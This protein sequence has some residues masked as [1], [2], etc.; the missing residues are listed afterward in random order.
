M[1]YT[2]LK[3]SLISSVADPLV[4][5]L[6]KKL[7]EETGKE[8]NEEL[9]AKIDNLVRERLTVDYDGTILRF[10][11]RARES[12]YR[13]ISRELKKDIKKEKKEHQEKEMF[14][15]F[16]RNFRFQHMML[17]S[18]CIIL[19]LTGMPLKFPDF[20][21]LAFLVTLFGGIEN[22]TIIHRIGAVMLIFVAVY[23]FGWVIISKTGRKDFFGLIPMPK[24]VFDFFKMLKYF[25]GKSKE[26]PRFG[27]FSYIEKFDYWAVYWG[28]VIMI[29]SGL[30]LWYQDIAMKFMPKFMM[31][32]STEV[33]S[34][35]A[36]LATLSIVIWHFYNVHFN[37]HKFPG[38][39]TWW[40]GKISREEMIEEHPLEY[41]EIMNSRSEGEKE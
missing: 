37:P 31:D 27:R 15:R 28:C 4:A 25:A 36:L 21:P 10:S 7:E 8:L 14:L 17:M 30:I 35:E 13:D 40:H 23:H 22:S 29:G 3:E 16:G 24:D 2:E 34:D 39:L 20:E 32:I 18:S 38:S 41:E 1:K 6:R 33:H 5:E 19:I 26:K 11:G 12:V 9:V